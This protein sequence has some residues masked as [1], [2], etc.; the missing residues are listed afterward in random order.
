MFE[1]IIRCKHTSDG[2][3]SK[4]CSVQSIVGTCHG[5]R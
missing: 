2:Y 4:Q 1:T 5:K 3:E